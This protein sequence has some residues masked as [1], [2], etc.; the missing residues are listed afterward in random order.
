MKL[1]VYKTLFACFCVFLLFQFTIGSFKRNLEQKIYNLMTKENTDM[2]K[3]KI[4]DEIRNS[5][6]KD[7]ILNKEDA[8]LIN[9]F[10]NKINN[11]LK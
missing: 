10:L 1:F 7:N 5:L 4:R 9:N 6:K 3:E 11:E 8:A 2:I